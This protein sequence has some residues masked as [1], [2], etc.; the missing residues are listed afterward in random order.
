MNFDSDGPALIQYVCERCQTRFVLPPSRRKLGLGGRMRAS[1]MAV[2]RMFRHR[3]GLG[4]GY[5]AS[6]RVLLQKM[7]DDAYQ[8]FVQSFRFCHECRKFVC[9]DCWS[10][11]RRTCLTCAA[12]S[13]TG[14]VASRPPFV[15][16]VPEV[17]RASPALA[18]LSP[19]ARTPAP[20]LQPLDETAAQLAALARIAPPAAE[21]EPE[22]EVLFAAAAQPEPEPEPEVLFTYTAE[23]EPERIALIPSAPEPLP[24]AAAAALPDLEAIVAATTPAPAPAPAP[25]V[26]ARAAAQSSAPPMP[27]PAGPARRRRGRL[28][29]D[30]AFLATAAALVLVALEVGI[31]SASNGFAA[32][33]PET[34]YVYP[35]SGATM[36]AVGSLPT[37]GP[38][39]T[40]TATATP[41]AGPTES[42]TP[43]PTPT[44]TLK[45]GQTPTP[46][47]PPAPTP[48]KTPTAPPA[49]PTP[50]PTPEPTPVQLTRP[51]LSCAADGSNIICSVPT[52][53]YPPAANPKYCFQDSSIGTWQGCNSGNSY[54]FGDSATAR[55]FY[56][57]VDTQVSGYLPSDND[58]FD[59]TP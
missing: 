49:S 3:E 51:V 8:S 13:M 4:R 26:A 9:N 34:I 21:P 28:L 35:T 2:G 29:R 15:P 19:P 54:T 44:P 40:A 37:A 43:V 57:Y 10:S 45:P 24:V 59:Y 11:A 42:P 48:R 23:P 58:W 22:P 31:L 12:K 27:I 39:P 32:P 33:T 36:I 25:A 16:P 46:Y 50:S 18:R 30:V 53:A 20:A 38:T 1:G 17:Q 6:R 52:G 47:H 56:V 41:T 14:S 5:D 7:D 55:R